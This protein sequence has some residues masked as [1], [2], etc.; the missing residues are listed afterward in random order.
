MGWVHGSRQAQTYVHLSGEQQ[1]NAILRAYGLVRED[2]R[3][4]TYLKQCPGC[5]QQIP[6]NSEFCPFCYTQFPNGG[7]QTISQLQTGLMLEIDKL[8]SSIEM[9]NVTLAVNGADFPNSNVTIDRSVVDL[10]VNSV[11]D[12][13]K[14]KQKQ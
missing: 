10:I 8:R 11:L 2:N 3:L 4:D 9:K 5:G 12:R 14:E 13:L 1:R 6:V 7:E